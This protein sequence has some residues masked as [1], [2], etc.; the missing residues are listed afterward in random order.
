MKTDFLHI[1]RRR[2]LALAGAA[3]AG[4]LA[5]AFPAF[6]QVPLLARK[7][8]STGEMLPSV[9]I[10]TAII[11]D[12]ENDK[13]KFDMRAEVLKTLV[14]G[15]G[16][17]IDTAPSYGQAEARLGDLF[18]A[19]GL[20]D[21]I[22]LATKVRVNNREATIAEM[23]GS[24]A[25]LKADKVDLMQLHNPG[26]P[27]Q[28]LAL[29]REWKAQGLCRYLGIS[30]SFERDYAAVEAIVKRE[31][32]DFFQIDYS[33]VDRNADERLIPAAQDAGCAV[34][35]N[36]PFGRGRFF[37]ATAGKPLPDIAKDIDATSWAQFGLKWLLG[38]PAVTAV[39]PG[40]DR[41]EYMTDNLK[42]G[43]GRLP[44]PDMRKRMVQ[45]FEN[46]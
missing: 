2:A 18:A 26:N 23:K 46:L 8:P 10:G 9:G 16:K 7:I 24:F 36:L 44:D 39:I 25:R 35:T 12:F 42:A 14:A 40:T 21:R 15:G 27:D 45:V 37:K 28:D 11:F 32:P 33:M 19:T 5:P 6:A 22:F 3:A 17:L 13:E 29:L 43:M 41:P 20:R 38:N 30:S 1:D 31:K 4:A 34:L